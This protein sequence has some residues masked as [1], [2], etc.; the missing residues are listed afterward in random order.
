MSAPQ[1][2]IFG[3]PRT[4]IA[5][6]L[7]QDGKDLIMIMWWPEREPGPDRALDGSLMPRPAGYWLMPGNIVGTQYAEAADKPSEEG[8]RSMRELAFAIYE[9]WLADPEEQAKVKARIARRTAPWN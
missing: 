1:W 6:G 4:S 9:R 3:D 5:R 8:W 2:V 7:T